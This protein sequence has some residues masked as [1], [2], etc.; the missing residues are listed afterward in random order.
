MEFN[1]RSLEGQASELGGRGGEKKNWKSEIRKQK[2]EK[3]EHDARREVFDFVFFSCLARMV[4]ARGGEGASPRESRCA[5]R[6]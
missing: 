4:S 5:R 6:H 3:A 1:T 2:L